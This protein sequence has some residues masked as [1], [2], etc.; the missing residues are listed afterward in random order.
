MIKKRCVHWAKHQQIHDFTRTIFTD[1]SSLQLF[2]NT[3]HHWSKTRRTNLNVY[4]KIAKFMSGMLTCHTFTC[5]A[6]AL[7][8]ADIPKNYLPPAAREQ[9]HQN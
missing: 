4:L 5:N 6:D 8:Y 2:R 3:I 1:E 7:Y 9:F